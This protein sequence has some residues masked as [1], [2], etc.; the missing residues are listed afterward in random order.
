MHSR[1]VLA[2]VVSAAI[3]QA[4][5]ATF[6]HFPGLRN[7]GSSMVGVSRDGRVVFGSSFIGFGEEGVWWTRETGMVRLAPL[8]RYAG[9]APLA[10]SRDGGVL[11]GGGPRR[12]GWDEGFRWT[13]RD[14]CVGIGFL[15]NTRRASNAID[16]S[17][18]GSVI[19]G[20]DDIGGFAGAFRWTKEDGMV[21]LGS[22]PGGNEFSL[23]LAV[24]PDGRV[25]VGVSSTDHGNIAFRWTEQEG[26]VELGDLPGDINASTATAVSNDGRVVVGF[27]FNDDGFGFRW[28]ED[29]GLQ[30]LT[31]SF[32]PLALGVPA[33][34]RPLAM[35]ADGSVV[36]G[37]VRNSR[38][39]RGFVWDEE[40]GTRGFR[41]FLRDEHGLDLEGWHLEFPSDISDD[42]R[43]LVGAGLSPAGRT[44][45]WMIDLGPY[46]CPADLDRDGVVGLGDVQALLAHF[47]T[48]VIGMH[49]QGDVNFDGDIDLQDLG[50]M[51]SAFGT[52]CE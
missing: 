41:E 26:L 13:G 32:P 12:N 18:D 31:H 40:C 42:G 1:M 43:I 25:I 23:A 7:D 17:A 8:N 39:I 6:T 3:C 22:L 21:G 46:P 4:Q 49:P 24:T 14:G 48:R 44:E 29:E 2:A 36:V 28:T 47:G 5:D 50:L 51:L 38:S 52:S 45:G 27:S 15:P 35:S 10:A 16:V 19:V 30:P 34:I 11:V 37:E 20:V 9:A 33:W